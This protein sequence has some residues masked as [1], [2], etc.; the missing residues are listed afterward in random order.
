MR[1]IAMM[2]LVSLVSLGQGAEPASKPVAITE[3]ERTKLLQQD[4]AN[5][6]DRLQHQIANAHHYADDGREL[7]KQIKMCLAK[8]DQA[9]A[10]QKQQAKNKMLGELA[11]DQ[12]ELDYLT[13]KIS[14]KSQENNIQVVEAELLRLTTE[15]SKREDG[16]AKD[17]V[18]KKIE[19]AK[20]RIEQEKKKLEQ[21]KVLEAKWDPS[22]KP[23]APA[24]PLPIKPPSIIDF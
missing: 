21:V 1:Y 20:V 15:L 4:R 8:G 14:V 16:A 9:G 7:D 5:T 2:F 3:E 22:K 18:K 12:L 10:D 13:G 24:Q 11:R 6:I 23:A 19:E 17:E